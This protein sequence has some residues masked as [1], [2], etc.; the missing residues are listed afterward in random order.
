MMLAGAA[1]FKATSI[2]IHEL[3]ARPCE[4]DLAQGHAD[5]GSVGAVAGFVWEALRFHPLFPLVARYCP[6]PTR[7][8]QVQ[9][10]ADSTVVLAT[11]SAMF[12]P[13]CVQ[14][15]EDFDP[16]RPEGVYLLFGGGPH[17]CLAESLARVA[18]PE[19]VAHVLSAFHIEK[20]GNLIYDGTAVHQ[21]QVRIALRRTGIRHDANRTYNTVP[22]VFEESCA[23]TG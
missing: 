11:L 22:P 18:V 19:V 9:V 14:N 1:L 10:D 17:R 4:R 6:R 15:P 7:L 5:A 12:D 21:Y 13:T 8:G 3:C 20:S 16:L 23:E 2:A